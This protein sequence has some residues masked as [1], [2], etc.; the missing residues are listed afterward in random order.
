MKYFHYS[1]DGFSEGGLGADM[2]AH[3][4]LNPFRFGVTL[5]DVGGTIVSGNSIGAGGGTV[6]DKVP[7]RVRPGAGAIFPE[8][9]NWPITVLLDVDTLF[10]LQD[11][12]DARIFAGTEIWS[13]QDRFA[14]RTGFQQGNGPTFGFGARWRGFQ[15]DYAF[16][17]SLQ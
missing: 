1:F 2:G 3:V 6:K 15:L 5:T 7:M 12:Q 14:F 10:K 16:L 11:A 9:F 8:P 17:Y 4:Q 13:F